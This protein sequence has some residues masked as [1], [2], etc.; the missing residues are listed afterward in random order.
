MS[1]PTLDAQV[2]QAQRIADQYLRFHH[3]A[4]PLSHVVHHLRALP[5]EIASR[6][7]AKGLSF[8][9]YEVTHDR[10]LRLLEWDDEEF[11][12]TCFAGVESSE[13]LTNPRCGATP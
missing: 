6:A 12:P 10:L 9:H 3:G 7:I 11:C 13:H 2:E 4:T 5:P 8:G 1:S